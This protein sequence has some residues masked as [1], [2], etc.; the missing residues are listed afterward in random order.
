MAHTAASKASELTPLPQASVFQQLQATPRIYAYLGVLIG[1]AVCLGAREVARWQYIDE[2]FTDEWGLGETAAV[3]AIAVAVVSLTLGRILDRRDPRPYVMVALALSV[4]SNGLVGL[5][6]L[7]GPLAIWLTLVAAAID[8]AALGVG[9]VALLKTQAALVVPGAEGAAEILNVLRLGIGGVLGAVLAGLSP[10]PAWTLLGSVPILLVSSALLWRVMRPIQPRIPPPGTSKDRTSLLAY[11]RSSPLLTRVVGVD[12]IL[13]LVIPTQL[14]N[15]VLTNLNAPEIAS[16]SIA[17]G[18]V[19]VLAGRMALTLAGFRGNP[20]VILL[21]TVGSL[22]L[23]QLVG[24]LSLTDQWLQSQPL[25][26]PLIV[27]LGSMAS[28]YAQGLLAA[29]IQQEVTENYRGRLGSILVAGRNI[30]IS[31]G[32]LTGALGAATLGSQ[33]LILLLAFSLLLV[34]ALTRGFKV[35]ART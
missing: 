10:D 16:L 13:A 6:L 1:A 26:L 35:L 12:L 28:T 19:G 33:W 5:L 14:V 32:A 9:G 8:G 23:L 3:A 4:V 25:A 20:R 34:I 24:V 11:L 7:Q 18:M 27:I 30:L 17:S 15:L 29:I 31:V 21:V 22:C 2:T